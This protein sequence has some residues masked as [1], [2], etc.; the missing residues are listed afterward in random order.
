MS[1][2]RCKHEHL[3]YMGEQRDEMG[4]NNYYQC[5]DC[6][7]FVVTTPA[8]KAFSLKGVDTGMA[9]KSESAEKAP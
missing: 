2:E 8:R 3:K 9:P 6:G 1:K 4:A 7:D 5:L